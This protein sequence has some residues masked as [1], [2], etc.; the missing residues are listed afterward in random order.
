[1][2]KFLIL[3][4]LYLVLLTPLKDLSAQS[5]DIIFS[6][7]CTSSSDTNCGWPGS[8][9]VNEHHSRTFLQGGGANGQNAMRFN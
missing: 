9:P 5:S 3:V 4:L 2:K 1:M 6:M 8:V 7:N